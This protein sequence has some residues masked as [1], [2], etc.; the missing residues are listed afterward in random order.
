MLSQSISENKSKKLEE[1]V[2]KYKKEIYLVAYDV[3]KNST[4]S[5]DVVGISFERLFICIDKILLMD[6]RAE[7]A[8][9]MTIAKN[10]AIN[11]YNRR[12]RELSL[13]MQ[14]ESDYESIESEDNLLN[15][16]ANV[17]FSFRLD[18]A[19]LQLSSSDQ[20]ILFLLYK[21]GFTIDEIALTFGI[22]TEATKKRVQRA[23]NKVRDIILRLNERGDI[24]GF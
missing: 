21:M 3:L 7:K 15:I 22:S 18:E 23:R 2:E 19:I 14:L 5:E 4:D 16:V 6:S 17:K 9:I 20:D 11:Y 10:E 24:D 12:K 1:L 8:Y 13:M